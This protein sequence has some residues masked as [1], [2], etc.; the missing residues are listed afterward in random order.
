MGRA[1]PDVRPPVAAS[2]SGKIIC[3]RVITPDLRHVD[4]KKLPEYT[5]V[6]SSQVA[7][8]ENVA[9]AQTYKRK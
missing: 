3:T 6:K 9:N 7:F 8:N 4:W 5:Q 1:E 2:P